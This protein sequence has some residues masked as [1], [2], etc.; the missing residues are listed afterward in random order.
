MKNRRKTKKGTLISQCI[1]K[2]KHEDLDFLPDEETDLS[3]PHPFNGRNL[4]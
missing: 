3:C 2:F 4:F 1:P